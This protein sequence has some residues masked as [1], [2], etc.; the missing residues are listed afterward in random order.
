MPEPGK[1]N[2]QTMRITERRLRSIVRELILEDRKPPK[3]DEPQVRPREAMGQYFMPDERTDYRYRDVEEKDTPIEEDF[4]TALDDHYGRNSP[5]ALIRVWPKIWKIAQ[6]G[7]YSKW[8]QPPA[9]K[10]AYRAI[11]GVSLETAVRV[12]GLTKEDLQEEANRAHRV[13][14][15]PAVFRPKMPIASWTLTPTVD[16]VSFFIGSVAEGAGDVSDDRVSMLFEARCEPFGGGGGNFLMNPR[17]FS[18]D[19]ALGQSYEEEAE[20]ISHG[21]V[22]IE[23]LSYIYHDSMSGP[24]KGEKLPNSREA[25]S[26]LIKA[27]RG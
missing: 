27:L 20:V 19:F 26:M 8:L 3:P 9:K 24:N 23:S 1:I 11:G 21:P 25:A 18:R 13:E 16:L 22:E 6:S 2:S 12:T 7:L 17:N 14:G 15:S 10:K 5:G 4:I